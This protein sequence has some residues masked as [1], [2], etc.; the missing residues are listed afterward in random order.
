MMDLMYK[1]T[2]KAA[3]DA[4]VETWTDETKA[5]VLIDEIGPIVTTPAV[6]GEDGEIITPAMVDNAHHVNVRVM[7]DAIDC[8]ALAQGFHYVQWIDP[9]TVATPAR[10][11]A[12]GMNYWKAAA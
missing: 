12:G 3:W 5:G 1:A 4:W 11:W 10:E 9:A 6:I 2:D 7:D 8:A